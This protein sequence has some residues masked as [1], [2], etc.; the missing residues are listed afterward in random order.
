ID[1]GF[2]TPNHRWV[3]A[4]ALAQGCVAYPD[5][6]PRLRP[7]FDALIAEEPD[8]DAEGA[9][10]ERSIAIY[11]AVCCRALFLADAALG[12]PAGRDAAIRCLRLDRDLLHPDGSCETGLSH[13]Q[14]HGTRVVPISLAANYL[15]A[16]RHGAADLAGTAAWLWTCATAPDL[17]SAFW[18]VDALLTAGP[19]APAVAPGDLER[20]YPLN[21]C[22]RLRRGA[23]S[24][25]AF[26][27]ATRLLG[28]RW[29]ALEL[30][31]VQV[32][33]SYLGHG[34]FVADRLTPRPGGVTLHAPG[35]LAPHRLGY[36]QPL[37]RPVGK[38]GWDAAWPER[39]LRALPPCRTR[40]EIDAV[41]DGLDLR[42]V[43][44]DGLDGV[45]AQIAFDI[46]A[47]VEVRTDHLA[48]IV[49]TDQELWLRAGHAVLRQ[50]NDTL[51]I[52][53][54]GDAHR[55]YTM[56]DFPKT[57]GLGR[58]VIALRTPIDHRITIRCGR[59]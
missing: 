55:M 16:E 51:T 10:I 1:G 44:E 33:Q 21:G 58:V 42:V 23:L 49:G 59:E 25:T 34:R 2:H 29:G 39:G 36:S 57:N 12:W 37:G 6:A 18:S 17:A 19:A 53:P 8:I 35:H 26:T 28:L 22:W 11:D 54:G 5:L 52:G 15:L 32:G 45:T 46:P 14:D 3:T 13:R 48:G 4:S 50:G 30:A 24:A 47:G 56:R 40:I 31:A 20:A 43:G 41:A 27:G 9:F 38:D 7:V